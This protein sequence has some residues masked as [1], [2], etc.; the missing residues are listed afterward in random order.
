VKSCRE[1]GALSV[2]AFATHGVF[3]PRSRNDCW[4]RDGPDRLYVT[5]TLLPTRLQV[6][7]RPPRIDC[8][9]SR[10]PAFSPPRYAGITRYHGVNDMP[11]TGP[12][13]IK[14]DASS[15]NED[16]LELDVAR[17]AAGSPMPQQFVRNAYTDPSGRFFA[18]IWRSS[19]GAW[20]VSYTE[21][22]LCVLTAGRVR[23]SDDA[24]GNGLS[25]PA[26]A[27]SCLQIP[28]PVGGPR[29]GTEVL[30]HL[31]ASCW[32]IHSV[33]GVVPPAQ[34]RCRFSCDKPPNG[35]ISSGTFPAMRDNEPSR[36]RR[37]CENRVASATLVAMV[38]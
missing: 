8:R 15:G 35:P 7:G 16:K 6:A 3:A 14:V 31:R 38:L 22:E 11:A 30:R 37:L 1:A 17:L 19:V 13:V 5:D 2:S 25:D 10:S 20:R 18:G 21:N 34:R 28:G 36:G 26:T 33:R 32:L 4:A 9:C 23:I 12:A 27:S 24:G 29:A